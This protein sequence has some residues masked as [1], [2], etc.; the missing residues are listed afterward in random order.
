MWSEKRGQGKK[1]VKIGGVAGCP[2]HPSLYAIV[3]ELLD[4][5]L[6]SLTRSVRPLTPENL[7]SQPLY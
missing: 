2:S 5:F 6:S 1:F 3:R 7:R 4:F